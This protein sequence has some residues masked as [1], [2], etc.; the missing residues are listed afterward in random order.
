M[1]DCNI[2]HVIAVVPAH[3]EAAS[4]ARTIRRLTHAVAQ[5]PRRTSSRIVVVADGC[6]DRTAQISSTFDEVTIVESS[7]RCVGQARR[8]G[9]ELAL[10]RSDALPSRTW[11]VNT[12]A[13]TLVPA[14]WVSR[15]LAI[16]SDGTRAVAGI[17]DIADASGQSGLA[18]RFR[19][20]YTLGDDGTHQHVHGANLGFRADAYLDAGGW[21]PLHTGE[22]HDLWDRLRASGQTISTTSL[23]VT[24]SARLTGRAPNG[25]ACDLSNLA[26]SS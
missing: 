18:A 19:N 25:F 22:D 3:N 9:T 26:E 1:I 23:R 12:D 17:V 5:T 14:D 2:D 24:T 16:A 13:D 4:I 8:L 7:P 15:Q 11:I 10:S 21:R 6:T 20:N